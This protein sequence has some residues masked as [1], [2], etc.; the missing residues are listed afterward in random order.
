MPIPD[1][2]TA[3]H[4]AHN[5][6]D[7]ITETTP[8]TIYY[9][10]RKPKPKPE[11]IVEKVIVR[12]RRKFVL[13]E[14][15]EVEKEEEK[16]EQPHPPIKKKKTPEDIFFESINT[17][18]EKAYYK[19]ITT[20]GKAP[21]ADKLRKLLS[22]FPIPNTIEL[23][24]NHSKLDI[25][26]NCVLTLPDYEGRHFYLPPLHYTLYVL[27]RRHPEGIVLKQL[28]Q[29]TEELKQIYNSLESERDRIDAEQSIA[30]MV[31]LSTGSAIQK[32]SF[33]KRA[34]IKHVGPILA[35]TYSITGQRGGVYSIRLSR[36]LVILPEKLK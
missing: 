18:I 17:A 32:I 7:K 13:G 28:A 19:Y 31:D 21:S 1:L 33:I 35:P 2:N 22:N 29:H 14:K 30:N 16:K 34:F 23:S 24:A 26:K 3:I 11:G 15:Y 36:D 9:A 20:E 4:L 27:F 8:I 10:L 6:K 12:N 25:G 5:L